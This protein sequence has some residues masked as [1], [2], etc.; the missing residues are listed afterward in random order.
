[1]AEFNAMAA[2][3]LAGIID[4][5]NDNAATA[6]TDADA[7][8]GGGGGAQEDG[9]DGA[10]ALSDEEM[11]T[12]VIRSA[13]GDGDDDGDD[14]AAPNLADALKQPAGSHS[15]DSKTKAKKGKKKDKKTRKTKKGGQPPK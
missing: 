13:F 7:G 1:M 4:G 5:D 9:G 6:P 10:F 3:L 14:A 15:S 2:R 8:G 11:D 12:H